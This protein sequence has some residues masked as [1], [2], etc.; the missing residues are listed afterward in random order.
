ME[1][2]ITPDPAL[3]P[4]PADLTAQE[5]LPV[6]I[7]ERTE[8]NERRLFRLFKGWTFSERDGQVRQWVYQFG[9]DIQNT[10]KKERRWVCCLCI[11]QKNPRPKSYA[12]KGLQNAEVHLYEDHNG[13]VDPTGKKQRP[14]KSVEKPHRSI[15]TVLQL[16]AQEPREQSLINML[17]KRFDKAVFQQKLVNWIVNSNQSFSVVNDKDLRDI[18]TYLNPSVE[19]SQANI[20]DKTVRAVAEREFW[21]NRE[22]VKE[23]LRKS[24]GQIHIQ[25]DGWKSGN[26]HALYGITCV[27]RDSN[28][29]PQKCVLGLP[30]L[31]ERHTGENIAGQIIEIIKEFEIGDK[32]GYFT[33]DNAGNNKTSIEA[34]GLEFGFNW[35]NRWVRC[36]GH[37]VN[38]VVKHML[39]GKTPD[40]FEKEVFEG[41][42]TAAKEHEIWRKRGS[43]GKW[44]NFAVVSRRAL[45]SILS[46]Y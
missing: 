25:Y 3:P 1:I 16:N 14:E 15:A 38:I 20:T 11:K 32:L 17:I 12:V 6:A 27:F 10:Q 33:L 8:E 43:V 26:R 23:V 29:R 41:I 40:A 46:T 4:P 28:N 21:N 22:K 5:K 35:E 19:I 44:H 9:Y 18:F 7:P 37:V 42:H 45:D 31:T 39:F 13:I 34:L 30:E 24:P 2:D 36:I